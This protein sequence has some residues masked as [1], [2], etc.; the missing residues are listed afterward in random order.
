MRSHKLKALSVVHSTISKH[1]QW[2]TP[3]FQRSSWRWPYN[4]AETCSWNYNL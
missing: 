1:Y 4:W 2:Y 3:P